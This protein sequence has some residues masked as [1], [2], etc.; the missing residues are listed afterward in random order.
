MSISPRALRGRP[1]VVLLAVLAAVLTLPSIPAEARAGG[2]APVERPGAR[3]P[4]G[5]GSVT[6]LPLTGGRL[7]AGRTAR[8]FDL[9]GVGWDGPARALAGGTVKVRVRDAATGVWSGWHELETDGEDGP[10]AGADAAVTAAATAADGRAPRGATAPLWTGPSDGVAV[11]VT[12][13][14]AGPPPG[15]RVELVDPGEGVRSAGARS[16]AA[17][18]VDGGRRTGHHQAP[19][20]E[21]VTRAG[22]GADESI[23]EPDFEY[24]GPVRV[25]FV[26]HTATTTEYA[27]S[28]AP[29]LIRAIY[30]YHVQSNGWRDIGY[31]FLVDRCGT[32]YEGRAGGTDLPVHGAH[33][34]GF[35]TDSAGVAAIGTFVTD[36]PPAPLLTGVARIAAWKLGLTEQDAGGSTRL[37]SGSDGSL[38]P[39]GTGAVFQAVSGHRDAFNTECPGDALYP[40]LPELRTEAARLQGR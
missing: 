35:N 37:V 26:H 28:D 22:W 1:P 30:Q 36:L 9:L 38:Y 8:R 39:A 18:P 34:L 11:E 2:G 24:T 19:R 14:P 7:L 32:V 13:G 25:V 6:S 40:K 33:T 12:P 17:E 16:T 27:C 29:R 20:P 3:G 23:R 31:N 10:D 21:I 4:A 5:S 15:L